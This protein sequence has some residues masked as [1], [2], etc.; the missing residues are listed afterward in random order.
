MGADTS[1]D[2][3]LTE[4]SLGEL[5]GELSSEVGGLVR[6]HIDLVVIET[7]EEARK[8]ARSGVILGVA[9]VLGMAALV[10]LTLAGGWA[11]AEL[12][13]TGWAFA[14]VAA[15]WALAAAILV[16]VGKRQLDKV[17]PRPE[18]TIQEL[19]EDGEWVKTL[20]S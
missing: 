11:L 8:A 10:A 14:I 16:F 20:N 2:R 5:V 18:Q 7:R 6:S 9:A 15:V 17:E 3:S 4:P 12:M 13:P 1:A 19:K